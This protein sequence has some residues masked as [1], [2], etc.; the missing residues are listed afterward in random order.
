MPSA[1]VRPAAATAMGPTGYSRGTVPA[2]RA[3]AT[4]PTTAITRTPARRADTI[5]AAPA[6]VVVAIGFVYAADVTHV[7]AI[8]IAPAFHGTSRH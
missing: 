3:A 5:A 8:A 6:T 1:A 2:A 4:A 7:S